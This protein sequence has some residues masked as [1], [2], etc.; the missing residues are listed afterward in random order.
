[1]KNGTGITRQHQWSFTK[2]VPVG[3][4][5]CKRSRIRVRNTSNVF[6]VDMYLHDQIVRLMAYL[7]PYEKIFEIRYLLVSSFVY[8]ASLLLVW[9]L[10]I[11]INLLKTYFLQASFTFF[12]NKFSFILEICPK[13]L[14]HCRICKFKVLING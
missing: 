1:M 9:R 8:S 12:L 4:E 13:V 7:Q 11:S 2:R 14:C 10:L 3:H 6:Y 5:F